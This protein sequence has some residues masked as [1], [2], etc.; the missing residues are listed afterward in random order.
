MKLRVCVCVCARARARVRSTVSGD[1]PVGLVQPVGLVHKVD[2][3][4][5]L[6]VTG[7][8]CL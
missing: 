8:T 2:P 1:E 3:E 4:P 6:K 5:Y 7:H